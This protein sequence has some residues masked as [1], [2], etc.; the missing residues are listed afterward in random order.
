MQETLRKLAAAAAAGT[1]SGPITLVAGG[2]QIAGELVDHMAW[3]TVF[4]GRFPELAPTESDAI[5]A[6]T[7]GSQFYLRNATVNGVAVGWLAVDL[8]GILAFSLDFPED[9]RPL[10]FGG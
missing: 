6:G 10:L 5:M 2:S 8:A 1:V 3:A 4:S 7:E 9:T